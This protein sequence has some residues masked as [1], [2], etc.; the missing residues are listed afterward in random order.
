MPVYLGTKNSRISFPVQPV[1]VLPQNLQTAPGTLYEDFEAA[2]DWTAGAAS[3]AANTT[4]GEFK[5]GTQSIKLT[6]DASTTS[7]TMTKT[8]NWDLSG[9]WGGLSFWMY[10]HNA[11]WSDYGSGNLYM[12]TL[13]NN[14]GLT[15]TMRHWFATGQMAGVTKTGWHRIYIPKAYFLVQG[16]GTF[17]SPIIRLQLKLYSKASTVA[18]ASFDQLEVGETHRPAILFR[19]DDSTVDHYSTAYAYMKKFGIRGTVYC[20]PD[21]ISTAGYIS[22]QQTRDMDVAGWAMAN[23]TQSHIPLVGVTEANQE[24]YIGNAITSLTANG[25]ARC[26]K[27]ISYPGGG[28]DPG[29]DANTV[30]AMTNLAMLTGHSY[31]E[32]QIGVSDQTDTYLPLVLP[33]DRYVNGLWFISDQGFSS[34]TTIAAAKSFVDTTIAAGTIL[35]PLIHNIDGSGQ[36]TTA[37]F[38]AFVDYVRTK[39]LAGLIDVITIDDLYKLTLGSVAVPVVK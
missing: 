25:L 34:T 7:G 17:A 1:R 35:T 3:V 37:T 11:T 38:Q 28:T 15:N 12:I 16:S 14:S 2:G 22:W 8:V 13:S 18:E 10:L 30:T 32:N 23:H 29:Y 6:T 26:A 5:T 4:A 31:K 9:N 33:N 19:F 21:F 27:Y 20:V 39:A 24:A 36:W